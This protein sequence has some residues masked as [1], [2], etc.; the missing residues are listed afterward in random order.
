[1]DLSPPWWL[2]GAGALLLTACDEPPPDERDEDSADRTASAA[3]SAGKAAADKPKKKPTKPSKPGPHGGADLAAIQ[4]KLQGTWL[5][6]GRSFGASRSIWHIEG[7]QVTIVRGDK[8][9]KATVKV[10]APC[11]LVTTVTSPKG[12]SNTF[13]NFVFDGDELYSGLGNAG[14]K[15]GDKTVACFS[16]GI[17]VLDGDD[18]VRWSSSFDPDHWQPGKAECGLAADDPKVFEATD[19]STDKPTYGTEKMNVHG[20]VM[21]TAQMR[22]NRAEKVASL[23]E[24]KQRLAEAQK[25][26]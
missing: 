25:T 24:A 18:C 7:D 10:V 26:K 11:H 5:V 15:V 13:H 8:E 1:M 23:A 17:Y 4:A 3:K 21:M 14:T 9:E 12:S 6:G 2:L 20:D 19:T 22:G 16:G